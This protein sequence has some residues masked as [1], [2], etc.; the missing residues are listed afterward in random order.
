[1]LLKPEWRLI[2]INGYGF[3]TGLSLLSVVIWI[4][5]KKVASQTKQTTNSITPTDESSVTPTSTD[6]LTK[7]FILP[8]LRTADAV[9]C[10]VIVLD[11]WGDWQGWPMDIDEEFL[12]LSPDGKKDNAFTVK[13]SEL[14]AISILPHEAALD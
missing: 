6:Y 1:M 7:E 3:L 12:Y 11:V 10:P 13:I 8:I 2:A 5:R 9:G 4:L 14:L